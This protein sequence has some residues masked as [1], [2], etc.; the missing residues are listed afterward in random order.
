MGAKVFTVG[1]FKGGVGKTKIVT[2]LAYDN[3]AIRNKKTLVLDLDPQG[4]ASQV[5]AKTSNIERID[6]TITDAIS[7]GDLK[8]CITPVMTNLDLVACNTSFRSFSRFVLTNFKSELDQ[9][10]VIS[11]LLEPIKAEYDAIFID[12]PPTISEFSD[13]AMAAS[14]YSIIAFQTQEESLD[15]VSKYVGYQ[16][17][18]VDRYNIS[19]Q[20]I[21]IVACM[22]EPDDNLD[23]TILSEAREIYGD[24]VLDTV[25]TYQKRLKRYSREG[26]YLQ[27]NKN[28]KF[29]QWDYR[30][31]DNFIKILSELDARDSFLTS[32]S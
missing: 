26:I 11:K 22:I 28:G 27:K 19:L 5:L 7:S 15:G 14:D 1:N 18:M 21:A 2:M 6:R 13:N 16:N 32:D 9:I 23:Q 17:F 29:D 10:S 12:V 24:A 25:I 3:A 20:V 4:N 30:A 8:S 31:H